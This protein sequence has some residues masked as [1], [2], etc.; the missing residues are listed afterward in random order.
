MP[1]DWGTELR[2]VHE[3]GRGGPAVRAE[4]SD[5]A[6]TTWPG[7]PTNPYARARL[8]DLVDWL[9]SSEWNPKTKI[10]PRPASSGFS[11]WAGEAERISAR[12][13]VRPAGCRPSPVPRGAPQPA[14][15]GRLKTALAAANDKEPVD[16]HAG[17]VRGT[18]GA[19]RSAAGRA[20]GRRGL[21]AQTCCGSWA[22]A[23]QVVQACA[24]PRR[25]AAGTARGG[26]CYAGS[27][28]HAGPATGSRRWLSRRGGYLFRSRERP[29]QGGRARSGGVAAA[30]GLWTTRTLA[31][32]VRDRGVRRRA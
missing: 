16:G 31:R 13:R 3:G 19:P 8:D 21:K 14:S 15:D 9:G 7:W 28:G 26:R 30:R 5:Y 23:N 27:A 25:A 22:P 20:A 24:D 4:R 12:R 11:E 2:E 6:R 18:P 1:S 29:R 17:G 32:A 10:S